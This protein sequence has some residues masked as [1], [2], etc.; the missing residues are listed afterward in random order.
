M[1]FWVLLLRCWRYFWSCFAGI[2]YENLGSWALI[3]KPEWLFFDY[4]FA[5]ADSDEC[6]CLPI[7]KRWDKFGAHV[8]EPLL[9]SVWK[10]SST[11]IL[12]GSD[13]DGP[14][15]GAFTDKCFKRHRALVRIK[16]L[17]ANHLSIQMVYNNDMQPSKMTI[18]IHLQFYLFPINPYFSIIPTLKTSRI[19]LNNNLLFL[20]LLIYTITISFTECIKYLIGQI[21]GYII[22]TPL[23]LDFRNIHFRFFC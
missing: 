1:R 18:F 23:V 15:A 20:T 5:T 22:T 9:A 8:Y 19:S 12:A 6:K 11:L 2:N 16:Y 13:H 21:L 7:L 17:C 3:R 4:S 10:R 14:R